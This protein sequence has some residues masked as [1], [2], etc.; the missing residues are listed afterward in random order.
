VQNTHFADEKHE[1]TYNK[2]C[3]RF[4]FFA[5]HWNLNLQPITNAEGEFD[6]TNFTVLPAEQLA[7]F[8][9]KQLPSGAL[10]T[11]EEIYTELCVKR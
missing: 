7:V 3:A 10:H 1:N 11:M 6:E 8:P 2:R 4:R 9:D 5:K